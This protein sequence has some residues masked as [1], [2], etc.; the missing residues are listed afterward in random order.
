ADRMKERS[1]SLP[2]TVIKRARSKKNAV[3]MITFLKRFSVG[4]EERIWYSPSS[5]LMMYAL[6]LN[7]VLPKRG[8]CGFSRIPMVRKARTFFENASG[9]YR[10]VLSNWL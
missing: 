3:G 8:F 2:K 4:R 5:V 7:L 1:G 6:V 10:I 9:E